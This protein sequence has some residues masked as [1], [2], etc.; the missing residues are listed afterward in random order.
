MQS[1][2]LIKPT[3]MDFDDFFQYFQRFFANTVFL[4]KDTV[5]SREKYI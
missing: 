4:N 1:I 2:C 5:V 3:K